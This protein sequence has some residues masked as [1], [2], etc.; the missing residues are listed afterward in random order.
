MVHEQLGAFHAEDFGNAGAEDVG[1]E[2]SDAV[3]LGGKRHGEVGGNGALAHAAFAGGHSDDVLD[4]GQGVGLLRHCAAGFDGDVAADFGVGAGEGQHGLLGGFHDRLHE[5]V[6][7]LVEDEGE[8][9]FVAVD[10]NVVLHHIALHDVFAGAGIAD[11]AEGVENE[12]GV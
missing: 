4:A 12:F 7:K 2:Q 1:V 5:R 11:G 6:G 10:A 8:G 3:A 9:D